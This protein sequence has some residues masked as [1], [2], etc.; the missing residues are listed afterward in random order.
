MGYSYVGILLGF[1]VFVNFVLFVKVDKDLVWINFLGLYMFSG[2]E[3]KLILGFNFGNG[4]WWYW[5]DVKY[6]FNKIFFKL[7]R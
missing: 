2:E 5:L 4:V 7:E 1:I 3:F 6:G